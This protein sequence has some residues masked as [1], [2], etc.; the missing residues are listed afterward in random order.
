MSD[1]VLDVLVVGGGPAGA[2]VG[3]LLAR[4]LRVAVL[5]PRRPAAIQ[6]QAPM[7][8]RV[9]AISRASEHILS[10]AHAWDK[11]ASPRV[12]AYQRMCVWHEGSAPGSA[13]ALVFEA[14]EAGEPNLGYII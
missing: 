14:A 8:T 1:A 9:V 11:L 3:A 13:D 10:A 5:E 6:R 12:C 4:G 2:C 7:D